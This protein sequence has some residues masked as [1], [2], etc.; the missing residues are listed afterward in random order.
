MHL[1]AE[2]DLTGYELK[3]FMC[4]L[5]PASIYSHAEIN[6][7]CTFIP[8]N[9]L[10]EFQHTFFIQHLFMAIFD[11]ILGGCQFPPPG[12]PIHPSCSNLPQPIVN[13]AFLNKTKQNKNEVPEVLKM[14]V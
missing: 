2:D 4:I 6:D 10:F 13:F 8:E 12:V 3:H 5:T 14:Y 11:W 7:N 1:L 9:L